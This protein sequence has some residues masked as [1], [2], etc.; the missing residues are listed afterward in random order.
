[1]SILTAVPPYLVVPSVLVSACQN[2]ENVYYV[3]V[4]KVN[5]Y[6]LLKGDAVI[7]TQSAWVRAQEVWANV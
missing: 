3:P 5:A 4:E 6:D 1:M 2:L 7:M